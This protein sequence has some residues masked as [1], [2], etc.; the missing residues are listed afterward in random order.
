[1][2]SVYAHQIGIWYWASPYVN[3]EDSFYLE[4]PGMAT[5]M[6]AKCSQ[7]YPF[8]AFGKQFEHIKAATTESWNWRKK[9]YFRPLLWTDGEG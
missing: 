8:G 6:C 5:L 4:P 3:C 1:M 2:H 9:N 7:L